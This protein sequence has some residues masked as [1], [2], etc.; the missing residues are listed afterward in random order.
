V[1]HITS[2]GPW[3]RIDGI[4]VA[5]NKSALINTGLA[6]SI[7]VTEAGDYSNGWVYTGT[8]ADGT[9]EMT[10]SDWTSNSDGLTGNSGSSA[11]NGSSWTD[12]LNPAQCS[13]T[14]FN[15]YCFED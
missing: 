4:K 3:V 12:Y 8:L 5:D 14:T 2:D 6:V 11:I 15:L 1:E 13:F 9:A 7:N 10:C